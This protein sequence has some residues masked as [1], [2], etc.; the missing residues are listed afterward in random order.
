[1]RTANL[2]LLA[3][4]ALAVPTPDAVPADPAAALAQLEALGTAT[5]QQVEEELVSAEKKRTFGSCT[6]ANLKIRRE[7]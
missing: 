1:M 5:F 4:S 2:I 3:C 7:W 6:P